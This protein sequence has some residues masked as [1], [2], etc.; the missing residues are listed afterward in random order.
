M[1]RSKPIDIL[2]AL[3]VF[4]VLGRHMLPMASNGSST[5][6]QIL[7]GFVTLWARGGWIGV[8]PT[9]Y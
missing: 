6:H 1:R 4:L 5:L 8:A 3:A 2:R 7:H 9:S